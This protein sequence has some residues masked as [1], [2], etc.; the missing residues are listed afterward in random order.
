M[1]FALALL[2]FSVSWQFF[3]SRNHV[4][5]VKEWKCILQT[6]HPEIQYEWKQKEHCAGHYLVLIVPH[7]PNCHPVKLLTFS[8]P[9]YSISS[10]TSHRWRMPFTEIVSWAVSG[11]L[12]CWEQPLWSKW[13]YSY[14]TVPLATLPPTSLPI[15]SFPSSSY[16][17]W[18]WVI[19]MRTAAQS[20]HSE[21]PVP[22]LRTTQS[23]QT[24]PC[25]HASDPA[26]TA[27]W[28][29]FRLAVPKMTTQHP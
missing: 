12:Q 5:N 1:S 6:A 17:T 23:L 11:S 9:F 21:I 28:E 27:T 26:A 13:T 20:P 25:R 10:N 15:L 16:G 22:T 19:I 29:P 18:K 2:I 3:C 7:V 24:C 4:R 14:S 8:V